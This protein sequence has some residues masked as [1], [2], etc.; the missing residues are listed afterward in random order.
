VGIVFRSDR[1]E[2]DASRRLLDFF[3]DSFATAGVEAEPVPYSDDAPDAARDALLRIGAALVWVDPLSNGLTRAGL[4]RVLREVAARG[5]W[6]SAHPDVIAKLGT[7]QVL[8]RTRSLGWGSDTRLY[9]SADALRQ[10][11]PL[12]L[13]AGTRVLKQSRGN[14]GQ[15]IYR[16]ELAEGA[17]EEAVGVDP[18]LRVQHAERGSAREALRLSDL[19]RRCEPFFSAGPVVD[20]PFA[21]RHAEGMVRCYVV[22]DR[23]AGF[24]RQR[25]TALSDPAP[26]E[27]APPPPPPRVYVGPAQPELQA[28]RARLESTW[29]P[30]ARELLGIDA[31]ALPALWDAD[32][33]LGE[34]DEAGHDT[35]VLC[36]INASSVFPFPEEA[37]GVLAEAVARRVRARSPSAG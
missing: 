31:D 19:V 29:I 33:F 5:V 8:H 21:R 24:G 20:Q 30:A 25:V 16:V 32:F 27:D 4:D 17:G 15:G 9:E 18:L 10:G 14:G 22:H 11:L 12:A 2:N 23:V 37:R 34:R 26:G 36:E 7:K 28:L 1:G 35:Y 3:G 6:V 13:R